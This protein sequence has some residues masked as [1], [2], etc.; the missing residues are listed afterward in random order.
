MVLFFNMISET[1]RMF[2]DLLYIDE[3]LKMT[4]LCFGSQYYEKMN[5]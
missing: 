4:Q 5:L 1:R 3:N 2:T